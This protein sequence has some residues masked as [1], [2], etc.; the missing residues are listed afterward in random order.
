M[1][2]FLS[3]QLF[4]HLEHLNLSTS[5]W[6][7]NLVPILTNYVYGDVTLCGTMWIFLSRQL[8]WQLGHPNLS[9]GYCFAILIPKIYYQCIWGCHFMWH[10]VNVLFKIVILTS[11]TNLSTS[12]WF[13]ILVPILTTNVCGGA[14]L[15]GPWQ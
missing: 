8:F 6:F 9:T 13:A 14:T 5:N 7:A 2:V 4:W 12:Y 15:S 3:I 10:N 11:W 1:W